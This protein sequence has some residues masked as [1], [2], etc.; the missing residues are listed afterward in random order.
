MRRQEQ[1]RYN[2]KDKGNGFTLIEVLISI[3]ILSVGLLGMA[4]LTVGII[5]GNK[6]SNDLTTATILAQNKMEDI[7]RLGYSGTPT[8]TTTTTENYN[9][10]TDYTAYKRVTVT[11][12]ASPTSGMKTITVTTFW[13]D[14]VKEHSVELKTILY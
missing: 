11:T 9:S 6:F 4:S 12:V 7:R 1:H 10:I 5:N 3:V 14:A 8:T 2:K 13:Q